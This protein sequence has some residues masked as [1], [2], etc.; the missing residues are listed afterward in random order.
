MIPTTTQL[1]CLSREYF[2]KTH[3]GL[4]IPQC[5]LER[6]SGSLPSA[7]HHL[8]RHFGPL[9]ISV[10]SP[11]STT[12]NVRS[13]FRHLY[14][15]PHLHTTHLPYTRD[16]S[17]PCQASRRGVWGRGAA[18]RIGMLLGLERYL[19]NGSVSGKKVN[20]NLLK[21]IF[22]PLPSK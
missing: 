9:L 10:L 16:T 4:C 13:H 18:A 8:T 17:R 1:L 22:R 3:F 5:N 6:A 12:I 19:R 2:S 7:C 11:H 14:T 15:H 20:S 21:S